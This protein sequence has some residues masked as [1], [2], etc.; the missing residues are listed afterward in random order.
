MDDLPPGF[1]VAIEPAG[2]RVRAKLK[3]LVESLGLEPSSRSRSRYLQA[4]IVT[5]IVQIEDTGS[6]GLRGYGP[7][8]PVVF[9]TIDPALA[10]IHEALAQIAAELN[11]SL[12]S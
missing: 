12:A 6:R 2:R 9:E 5:T 8:G 7:L 11:R 3:G 1:G 10:D 4:L